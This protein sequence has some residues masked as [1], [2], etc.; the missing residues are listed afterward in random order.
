LSG[1]GLH[2][3]DAGFGASSVWKDF[4]GS[5]FVHRVQVVYE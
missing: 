1:G 4:G 2:V 3:L 5:A